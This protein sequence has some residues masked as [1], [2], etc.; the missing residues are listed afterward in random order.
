[1]TKV[2]LYGIIN[3]SNKERWYK[4]MNEKEYKIKYEQ[5]LKG[6]INKKDWD[7]YC[8]KI[9]EQLMEDNK[10]VLIRLKN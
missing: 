7:N 6:T 9:L 3:I 1:M 5:Y 4:G 8:F 10:D 2:S